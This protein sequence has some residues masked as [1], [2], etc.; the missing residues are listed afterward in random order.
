[1]RATSESNCS[2]VT[3]V[4]KK[5]PFESVSQA[6]P[7]TA[8]LPA[9]RETERSTASSFSG[10]SEVSVRVPGVMMREMRRS[11]R[12]LPGVPSCSAITM[13]SPSLTRR[14]TYWSSETIGM[15]AIGIGSPF[16]SFPRFVSVMPIRRL[17]L[18]ASS[19]NVS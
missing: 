16:L 3:S 5:S 12:P 9:G 2:S 13:D 14:A 17:A 15:P 7:Q 1:M 19:K 6:K 10:R 18:A 4:A 8:F 11:I